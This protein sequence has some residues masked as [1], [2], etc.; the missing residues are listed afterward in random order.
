[1]DLMKHLKEAPAEGRETFAQETLDIYAPLA[2]RLGLSSMKSELEDRC[3]EIIFPDEYARLLR[4]ASVSARKRE[5]AVE[6][7][8]EMLREIFKEQDLKVHIAGRTK[9]LYSTYLK[10][11][12]QGKDFSK[13]FDLAAV[14]IITSTTPE[15]YQVLALLHVMWTPVLEEFDNY[16]AVPKPNGYQS[17]HTVVIA[18]NGQ[19]VEVQI[20][21]W[22]MHMKAEYG[23]AAHFR[24]KETVTGDREVDQDAVSWVRQIA[25]ESKKMGEA[26]EGKYADN[27]SLD[28]QEGRV[29]ALTP[30][31][32][33][34]SLAAGAT[35]IDFAYRIHTSVGNQ[36]R[37]AKI[38][39]RIAPFDQKLRNG[40]VVDI[41]IQKGGSPSRDWLRFVATPHARSK[42]R[43]WFKKAGREENL[44][45]G[46]AIFQKEIN[47]VGMRR[48]DILEKIDRVALLRAF[49]MKTEE[50]LYAAIGCGDISLESV[51]EWFRREYRE[52][53]SEEA[54]LSPHGVR[55]T[56]R[57]RRPKDVIVEGFSDVMV[58]FPKCC[59]PV[60]GDEI[61]GFVTRARGL[62][63]HR[64]NCPNV[65]K[66]VDSG[67]RIVT[68]N[69]GDTTQNLYISEIE[70][71]TIDRVG[72]LQEILGIISGAKI[73]CAEVNSKIMRNSTA[74][75]TLRIEISR[76]EDL[77]RILPRISRIDDVLSARRKI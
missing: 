56:I 29:F 37:G 62:A 39:G 40:D 20:R 51:I 32:K 21:T 74:I 58:S 43:A 53:L 65:K 52:L 44:I 28:A 42:I 70:I 64:K 30:K 18:P 50:D 38:N 6:R 1:M 10:M 54:S 31:G 33:V 61:V 41:L 76:V 66:Y 11:L 25:D 60:P 34:I 9:H 16:I 27:L 59:F 36:C 12:R 67:D 24:Y 2:H 68:V 46:R 71:N 17:I 49:N 55:S 48:K 69:W 73:N 7:I 77:D 3:F 72:V 22:E 57:R 26:P 5:E 4:L 63:V 13:L 19:P 75:I 14:R 15:C 45:H 35:P 8:I 23:I 47:R